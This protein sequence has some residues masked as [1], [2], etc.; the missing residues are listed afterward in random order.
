MTEHLSNTVGVTLEN[1]LFQVVGIGLLK[2]IFARVQQDSGEGRETAG[3]QLPLSPG[4]IH[5]CS[6]FYSPHF[7]FLALCASIPHASC[8]PVLI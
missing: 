1:K 8:F 4:S 7:H 3:H 2:S 6:T 5:K